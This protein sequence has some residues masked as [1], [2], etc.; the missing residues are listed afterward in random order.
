MVGLTKIH[1]I[2][3]VYSGFSMQNTQGTVRINECVFNY[4]ESKL[5]IG[6]TTTL[7]KEMVQV[8]EVVCRMLI[9]SG[10]DVIAMLLAVCYS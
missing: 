6:C 8:V 9:R 1:T 10:L 4:L 3:V 5:R 7:F 2:E